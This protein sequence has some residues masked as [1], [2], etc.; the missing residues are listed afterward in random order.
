MSDQQDV[1]HLPLPTQDAMS[2]PVNE[3]CLLKLVLRST[4]HCQIQL[5]QVELEAP[6]GVQLDCVALC[7]GKVGG[8]WAVPK[9]AGVMRKGDHYVCLFRVKMAWTE[10]GREEDG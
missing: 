9:P 3:E 6:P 5:E 4:A 7:P 2:L 8:V 1:P 10:E